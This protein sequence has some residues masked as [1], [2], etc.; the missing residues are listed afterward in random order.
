MSFIDNIKS[1]AS[2]VRKLKD[3]ELMKRFMN[4]QTSALGL[5]NDNDQLR[6]RI[7]DL[8]KENKSLE[9]K[10]AIKGSL[11]VEYGAYFTKTSEG[12]DGPYCTR[13]WDVINKL[14]RLNV[15]SNGQA[16]CPECKFPFEYQKSRRNL[17][18]ASQSGRNLSE[19]LSDF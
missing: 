15:R 7:R 6:D 9:E 14:V 16:V 5:Q 13:C 8:E 11:V 1:L 18:G 12:K 2:T 4:L 19:K 17:I 10:I 3:P